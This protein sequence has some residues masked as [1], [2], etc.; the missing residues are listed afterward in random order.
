MDRC[1]HRGMGRCD[2]LAESGWRAVRFV[3][4]LG[5]CGGVRG[6]FLGRQRDEFFVFAVDDQGHA[7]LRVYTAFNHLSHFIGHAFTRGRGGRYF[8]GGGGRL[9]G[10]GGR[11]VIRQRRAGQADHQGQ[12]GQHAPSCLA[13]G[14]GVQDRQRGAKVWGL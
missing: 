10:S 9:A 14:L 11:R 4:R 12:T 13:M 8:L 5:R 7:F 1:C 6:V 3:N 2:R